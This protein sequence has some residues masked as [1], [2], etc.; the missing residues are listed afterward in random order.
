[1]SFIQG[2]KPFFRHIVPDVVFKSKKDVKV[3]CIVLNNVS[4]RLSAEA[5]DVLERDLEKYVMSL[6][7]RCYILY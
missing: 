7:R 2:V 1:M 5:R 6:S 4:K 3:L